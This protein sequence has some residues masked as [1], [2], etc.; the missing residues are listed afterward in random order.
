[1]PL[2]IRK[3][4]RY[5]RERIRKPSTF[6]KKS[7][8]TKKQGKH[9]LIIGCPKGLYDKKR[10]ICLIGTRTQSILHPKSEYQKFCKQGKCPVIKT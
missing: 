8:R 3:K 10:K 7:M 5:I 9:R 4:G 6:D 2:E 1:M